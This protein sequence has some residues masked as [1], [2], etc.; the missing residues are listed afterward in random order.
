MKRL[1]LTLSLFTLITASANSAE[2]EAILTPLNAP[3]DREQVILKNDGFQDSGAPV[4]A[5]LGFIKGEKA[6]VWV[7]V[8][9]Y[10]KNFKVDYFRVLIGGVPQRMPVQAFF[11]MG[12][13]DRMSPQIPQQIE[14]AVQVTAGPYWN[15]IPAQGLQGGLPC[16]EGGQFIGAALEFVHTG[17]PSVYRDSD[18]LS[19]PMA[20]TLMA[21]PGGWNYSVVFGLQG[22]WVLRVV[23][24]EADASECG[25][26]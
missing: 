13:S 18:G 12:V 26:D 7:K 6:G 5:Q 22:D 23:G 14:N 3:Q 2:L 11:H 4:Y 8:P 19:N 20:N 1:T 21:I 15:D 16:V 25:R 17:P 9:P 24:H 10:A